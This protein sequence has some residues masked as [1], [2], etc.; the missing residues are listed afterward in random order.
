MKLPPLTLPNGLTYCTL[1]DGTRRCTGAAM[2]RTSLFPNLAVPLKLRLVRVR[3]DSGG[4]DA[5]GAYWGIGERLYRAVSLES[6]PT[7][8]STGYL[9]ERTEPVSI[10]LR[11]KDRADAKRR[12][13]TSL[14]PGAT[15]LH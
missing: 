7:R 15:F 6:V 9:T 10:F 2:G 13:C 12:L 11:A 5:G 8:F 14:V 1:A 4:Y 3:L